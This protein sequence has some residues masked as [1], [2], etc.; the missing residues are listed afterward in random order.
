MAVAVPL[1]KPHPDG[2]EETVTVNPG[3]SSTDVLS[4]CEQFV[5]AIETVSV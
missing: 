3:D 5:P 1:F 4:V 2:V